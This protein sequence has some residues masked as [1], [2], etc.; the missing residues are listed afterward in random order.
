[1]FAEGCATGFHLVL[2]DLSPF[3]DEKPDTSVMTI[4][5]GFRNMS[6]KTTSTDPYPQ[7]YQLLIY[8][9][10][11]IKPRGHGRS[12]AIGCGAIPKITSFS[13]KTTGKKKISLVFFSIFSEGVFLL[14][15]LS[16]SFLFAFFS[17]FFPCFLFAFFLFAFSLSFF[18]Y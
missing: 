16:V 8:R 13:H 15:F 9:V 1:M 12:I 18:F 5:H 10:E 3:S 6:L 17:V 2:D 14:T 11:R 4:I 7:H